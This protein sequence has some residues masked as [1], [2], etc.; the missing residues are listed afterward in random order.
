MHCG[1]RRWSWYE[2]EKE[3][4]DASIPDQQVNSAGE[5]NLNLRIKELENSEQKLKGILENYVESDSVLRNRMNELEK[6]HKILLVTID[7]LNVKLHQVENANMRVK[8]KLRDIRED[9]I[10]LVENQEKSEKKQKEKLRWLQEQ[11]KTKEDEIKSQSDYFEHYKQRQRQKTAVLRERECYL[12]DEVSR[13]EE[14]VL[15]LSAHI[16]LLTSKIEEGMAQYLQ[17]KLESVFSGTQC[18]KYS[19]LEVMKLKTCIENVKHDMISHLEAFQ[20]NLKFFREKEEYYRREKADLLTALQYSQ[21]TEDFLRRK[22]EESCHLVYSLKLSKIKLQEKMEELLDENKTLKDQGMVKLKKKKEKDSQL[23]RLEN[24]GETV[25]P[26]G[27][28]IQDDIP[29]LK[30]EAVMDSLKSR[31]T[32]TPVVLLRAK[33]FET[34]GSSCDELKQMQELPE[35]LLPVLEH[36]SSAFAKVIGLAET[37]QVT[38]GTK[39][40]GALEDSFTLFRCTPSYCVAG[41][42]PPCSEK[43]TNGETSKETKGEEN[44]SLLK[45]Q[46]LSLPAKMF[47]V[48][49]VEALMRKK[50]QLTLL[51][52]ENYHVSAVTTMKKMRSLYFCG[53]NTSLCSD[54]FCFVAERGFS[55]KTSAQF[56]GKMPYILTEIFTVSLE[57]YHMEKLWENKQI[58]PKSLSGNKSLDEVINDGK[59]HQKVF[60]WKAEGEEI[61]KAQLQ[62]VTRVPEESSKVLNRTELIKPGK[63]G[64]EDKD[65]PSSPQD[66][67]NLSVYFKDFKKH[68]EGNTELINKQGNLSEV[69]ISDTNRVYNR[70]DIIK[71]ENREQ[72]QKPTHQTNT[73]SNIGLKEKK[74]QTLKLCEPNENNSSCQKIAAE[75]M[76]YALSH[77]FLWSQEEKYPLN[78]LCPVQE[79]AV[80]LSKLFLPG[81]NFYEC[82]C[83]LSP[84]EAGN[85]PNVKI[86]ALEKMVALC[87]QRIFLL[88]QE[89]KKLLNKSLCITTGE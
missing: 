27:D 9:L 76:Q 62:Q 26:N 50:L 64:M 12:R 21:D 81:S 14:Q 23:T 10:N 72:S 74:D 56:C 45:E 11:L 75:N 39:R 4:E 42:F 46:G 69:C 87:S 71:L 88:M 6:S 22:L 37:E 55:D 78:I 18:C 86:C 70:E 47:P 41:L 65:S 40:A 85:D 2:A 7:Q 38:L 32:Q 35:E 30:W 59:Y 63:A 80:C 82:L 79:R 19:D 67:Q 33:E 8:G 5:D 25:D 49:V 57:K 51:E 34:P 20:Q 54:G 1:D 17:Q 73:S 58:L 60:R 3:L 68:F 48:S 53:A 13:L 52:P 44:F 31:V 61:Q 89:K 29:N 77:N 83:H 84:L 43:L 28:L 66:V 15:H 36:N 24:G 16:A